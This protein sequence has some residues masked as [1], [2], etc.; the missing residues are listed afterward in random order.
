MN[1]LLR[2]IKFHFLP[3][4]VTSAEFVDYLKSRGIE[5]GTG[6]YFFA[7]MTNEVDIQRPFMLKIGEYCKIASGVKI[8]CHDYSRSVLR[9]VYG[10]V[11]GEAGETVIG[12]NV[13]I[14][15]NSIILMGSHIGD[16]CIIGAGSIV[17]G[18]LENNSVYAGNPSVKIR[19]LE[20]HYQIRKKKTENECFLWIQKFREKYG[21]YPEENEMGPFWQLFAERDIGYLKEK[22]INFHLN[23]DNDSEMLHDF[24]NTEPLFKDYSEMIDQYEALHQESHNQH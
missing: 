7:P 4:K 13:F 10:E 22:Q 24:L 8:I 3:A 16:N 2:K 1:E 6:T 12:N 17:K 20:E 23:G 9:R 14:G 5:I 19:S 15:M 11:I 21:R 18:V